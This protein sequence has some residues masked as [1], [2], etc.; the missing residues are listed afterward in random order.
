MRCFQCAYGI[1]GIIVIPIVFQSNLREKCCV[2]A[3][4][5]SRSREIRLRGEALLLSAIIGTLTGS[6]VLPMCID[7]P[8]MFL[9]FIAA[10]LGLIQ[11]NT[12]TSGSGNPSDWIQ[13]TRLAEFSPCAR[14]ILIVY[15]LCRCHAI[16]CNL[17]RYCTARDL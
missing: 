15:Y 2:R 3:R 16:N 14:L 12:V 6:R 17:S 11:L 4:V 1:T 9:R 13:R 7:F 5:R 8:R 10:R